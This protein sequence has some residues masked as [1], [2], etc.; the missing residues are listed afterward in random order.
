MKH[1][2]FSRSTFVLPKLYT[3]VKN[4]KTQEIILS[5]FLYGAGE[6]NRTPV[7]SLEGCGST[8]K[9]HLHQVGIFNYTHFCSI[10]NSLP[11]KNEKV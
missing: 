11:R 1:H 7:Y 5:L 3:G 6:E 8:I 10:V 2:I 9:L 4:K